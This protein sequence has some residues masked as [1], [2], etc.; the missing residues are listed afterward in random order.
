MRTLLVFVAAV[1]LSAG[2]YACGG[3][4]GAADPT[5]TTRSVVATTIETPSST[6]PAHIPS[7][8]VT[9][10]ADSDKDNDLGAPHDDTN[11]DSAFNFGHE[12]RASEKSE[13]VSLIKHYY[14]A[15]AVENGAKACSLLFSTAAEGAPEDY[16]LSPPGPSYMRGKTCPVIL[17]GLF[18]H[19]HNQLKAEV[20]QLKVVS[21]R[22]VEHHGYGILTFGTMPVRLIGVAREGHI[23]RIESLYDRELD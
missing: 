1:L 23:W 8:P 14:A 2:L 12:A 15:A 20:P 16:G 18:K 13:I 7:A 19:Y 6:P 4:S 22:L 10:K 11:N 5:G 17:K 9:A 21:V 3:T